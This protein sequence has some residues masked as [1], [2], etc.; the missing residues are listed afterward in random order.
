MH[1]FVRKISL[2]LAFVA[3]FSAAFSADAQNTKGTV[4][5][6]VLD[7]KT[8][9]TL[10]GVKVTVDGLSVGALSDFDGNFTLSLPAGTYK[11]LF[12]NYGYKNKSLSDVA[13]K[14][15]QLQSLTV[16]MAEADAT[17]LDVVTITG[18]ATK[19]N[20][21]ALLVQQKNLA[22]V[23]DGISSESIRRTPDR[24]T[25]DVLKRV[26]GASIQDNKFAIVRGLND[27]YNAAYLNGAPLPSTEADRKAF[28]FDIFPSA[29]L[30]NLVIVKTATPE[31]PG[32]FAGGV[33][34]VNTKNFPGKKFHE[35][36]FSG[37]YNTITTGRERMDYQGGKLDWLGVDDGTRALPAGV[38][39]SFQMFQATP[40]ERAATAQLFAND[41]ALQRKTFLP[42]FSAQYAGGGSKTWDSGKK[43]GVIYALTYNNS[44]NYNETTR[45]SWMN[46]IIGTEPSQ[47]E[48]NFID[49]NYTVNT[50]GGALLNVAYNASPKHTF[51]WKNLYAVTSQDRVL[52]RYGQY[53]PLDAP[54]D[55]LK[56]TARWFTNNQIVS[57]QLTGQHVVGEKKNKVQW[58]TGYSRIVR[59]VP[60]LRNTLYYGNVDNPADTGWRAAV[61]SSSV[62]P[63]YSGSRFYGTNVEDLY[64]GQVSW[65]RNVDFPNAGLRNNVKAGVGGQYRDRTYVARQFGYTYF[66]LIGFNF[67]LLNQPDAQIFQP[68][69][70]GV[71]ADGSRGFTIREGTRSSDSYL[72]NA[73]LGFGFLQID[74]RILEKTRVIWGG[75]LE[76]FDQN[77]YSKT[78]NNDTVQVNNANTDF[79]PSVNLVYSLNDKQNLRL[80]FA[81]TV[82]RPEFRELAPFAFYDFT[83]RYVVT[84]NVNL[85]RALIYNYDARY[86]W[87][88]GRGQVFSVSAFY[89]DF[90]NPI[91]QRTREDVVTE[92]TFENVRRAVDWGFEVE[93]RLVLNTLLG[94]EDNLWS[95]LTAFA[96]YTWIRSRV[97]VRGLAGVPDSIRPLQGQSPYVINAGLQYQDLE[98]G[99]TVSAAFNR[100]GP[101]IFIVGSILEP[102]IWEQGRSVLDLSVAKDF[103]KD[104]KWSLRL[105]AKDLLAQDLI[106]FNDITNNQKWDPSDAA[107]GIVGDDEVWRT[108]FGPTITLGATYKF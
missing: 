81:Q 29:L 26:S 59:T 95:K 98:S 80:G 102:S 83:T 100:V 46:S 6:K 24:N 13:V 18:T 16:P 12:T 45:K 35:F 22:S 103:G 64:S 39:G 5:G 91:E 7:A 71:F 89:K 11:L 44:N 104:K 82:N 27:R 70:L 73:A 88:P 1:P 97:D 25:G 63:D 48:R 74:T 56:Q 50:L 72:A 105:T 37:G 2:F 21:T 14:A 61:T 20:A 34:Q 23:S 107:A 90:A 54:N 66:N 60:N 106:F 75:R 15:G 49:K 33:I 108:N 94:G 3:A 8:G 68:G 4:E 41:W 9:E 65:E 47:L 76:S 43:L 58:L 32:E 62:G 77:L 84:G 19:E 67:N 86:E 17:T 30:E 93:G 99:L 42:A 40:T 53:N 92:Y 31:L 38:P 79:L 52:A 101:R 36:S 69:N 96:N 51:G 10:P 57:T 87:Y 85:Q 78:D 55:V 28:S